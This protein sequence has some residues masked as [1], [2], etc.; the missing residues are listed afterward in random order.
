MARRKS[1]IL[2]LVT[3]V[4]SLGVA[5][6][7][8]EVALRYY[9][10]VITYRRT[11]AVDRI[12]RHLELRSDI[13][14]AWKPN[15]SYDEG[16]VLA[17]ADQDRELAKLG[18]DRWGFRNHAEAIEDVR[19][20][21]PVVVAGVGDSFMEMA[22]RPFYEFFAKRSQRYHSFA[23]HRQCTPQYNIILERYVLSLEPRY[24]LYGVFENDFYELEDYEAW[25][26]SG[27]DY[28]T[29]HSGF[30]CGP[31]YYRSRLWHP[32][33]YLAL[34]HAVLP[35]RYN[36]R[37]IRRIVDHALER[38]CSDIAA[39]HRLCVAANAHLLVLLIPGGLTSHSGSTHASQC[40]DGIAKRMAERG[41]AVL[42]LRPVFRDHPHPRQL[43]YQRDGHWNL[44]GMQLAARA[45][46][47]K[48]VTLQATSRSVRPVPR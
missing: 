26:E 21:R 22:A 16:I 36:D 45:I 15:I 29:Y 42:D 34:Y 37:R 35:H 44:Q 20:G 13:G 12:Q 5:V 17:W 11:E 32:K 18:T 28:F 6:M 41:V 24:V 8:G 33:G 25:R 31:P 4:V 39:A 48:L 27:M 10:D 14:F 38:I 7:I 9:F 2:K 19:A 23:M 46:D 47:L 43:Y 3:A 1:V 30:W 40:Y